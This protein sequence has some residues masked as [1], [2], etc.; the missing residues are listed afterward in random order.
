MAR[1]FITQ[2][3]YGM[4]QKAPLVTRAPKTRQAIARELNLSTSTLYRRLKSLPFEIPPGLIS[5]DL[6]IQIYEALGY[7]Y[8]MAAEED[9]SSPDEPD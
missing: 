8:L 9:L 5:P 3:Q 1:K 7:S 4:A 2:T 6:Q